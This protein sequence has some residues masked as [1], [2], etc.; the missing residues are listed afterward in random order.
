MTPLERDIAVPGGHLSDARLVQVLDSECSDVAA[1][2][3]LIE[4]QSCA[5]RLD[6]LRH[7]TERFAA[8]LDGYETPDPAVSARTTRRSGWLMRWVAGIVL[9]LGAASV[10]SPGARAAIIQMTDWI[11]DTGGQASSGEAGRAEVRFRS[12]GDT[13]SIHFL[14]RQEVGRLTLGVAPGDLASLS[15][16][17]SEAGIVFVVEG[18]NVLVRNTVEGR[19]DYQLTVPP[20]VSYLRIRVGSEVPMVLIAERASWTG[21]VDVGRN[22]AN[23]EPQPR[24][25]T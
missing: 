5:H 2:D 25:G 4:C 6:R 9:V 19:I 23:Q 18:G 13:V 22:G 10:A 11:W 3:H 16:A 15:A 24:G 20:T 8:L 14:Q 1:A 17:S 21:M 12:T 7:R